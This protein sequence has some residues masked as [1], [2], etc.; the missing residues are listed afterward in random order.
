MGDFWQRAFIYPFFLLLA[1]LFVWVAAGALPAALLFGAGISLRLFSHLRNI[2]AFDRWLSDPDKLGVPDGSGL[3]EDIF[4]KL[5]KL[6]KERRNER[7][8]YAAALQQME[9]ATSALPEGVVILD[10]AD[11]IEWCNLQAEQHF[12]LDGKRDIGQQITYLA[13]QPEFVQYLANDDFAK[14]L[15]LRGS[16]QEDLVL[17]IKLIA[18]GSSKRLMISRDI[19]HFERIETM[20]R[21]FVA[22]VSHELRTPLTVVNGFVETMQDM[23]NL[24]N[25][26]AR[27]ALQLMG[28]QTSRMKSLVDDLL[29]LSRLENEQNALSEE[30]IDVQKLLHILHEEGRSLSNGQHQIRLEIES[31]AGICGS[32]SELHS[33]FGNLVTNAVRYTPA[34]GDIAI[35]WSEQPD[36]CMV[37]SVKD[38]GI[39]IEPQ[40]ISRLTERFYRVDRSRSRETGGTGLGL[41]IVKH[42]VM[43]HQAQLNIV[44]EEGKGSTFSIVFPARRRLLKSGSASAD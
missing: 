41:A 9:Q 20:R 35:R 16:R 10:E 7:Q 14:P 25:D 29:T 27:R 40:H 15:V 17:S 44:S 34:G 24:E 3:W 13:R 23:P 21:D 39:G 36:G 6:T 11:R 43:R 19:T 42:I 5:N 33:A 26:M 18:Y 4:F 30:D 32:A 22:N 8:Q 12:G 31:E 2:A 1:S 28:N 38:S 37:F